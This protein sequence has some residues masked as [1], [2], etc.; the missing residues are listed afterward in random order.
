MIVYLDNHPVGQIETTENGRQ[1]SYYSAYLNLPNA[2]PVSL[3]LPLDP[4]PYSEKLSR[5]FFDLIS[6]D[7][8]ESDTELHLSCAGALSFCKNQPHS[9]TLYTSLDVKDCENQLKNQSVSLAGNQNISIREIQPKLDLC[10]IDSEF[11]QANEA[12]GNSHILKGDLQDFDDLVGNEIFVSLIAYNI[13]IPVPMISRVYLGYTPALVMDRPDRGA[14]EKLTRPSHKY[15]FESFSSALSNQNFGNSKK[16]FISISE[17]FDLIRHYAL[18]PALD[19][20]S[21]IRVI[22]LC[23]IT[24][25][26]DFS[27]ENQLIEIL[28]DH[29]CKLAPMSGFIS[30]DIYP[31]TAKR[32]LEYLFGI[33]NFASLK[34]SHLNSLAQKARI[35]E[36]YLV[37]MISELT[38][39]LPGIAHEIFDT[40]PALKSP[41]TLKIAKLIEQRSTTLKPLLHNRKVTPRHLE[42]A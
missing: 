27:L 15:H 30:T 5:P 10:I 42:V 2:L 29:T 24:G 41:T 22:T 9:P 8:W 20:R 32:F 23:L 33:S 35:N 19:C 16:H 18:V 38:T 7:I 1:F 34:K 4:E 26:D 28:P 21:L 36:K 17:Q 12:G 40:F 37:T 25:C 31:N 11:F 14:P 6:P 13:G 3:S 39:R